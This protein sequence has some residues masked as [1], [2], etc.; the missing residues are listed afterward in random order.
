MLCLHCSPPTSGP[1]APEQKEPH[2]LLTDTGESSEHP[3][4]P[5][6][7]SQRGSQQAQSPRLPRCARNDR[8]THQPKNPTNTI[9]TPASRAEN[10][11]QRDSP[12]PDSQRRRLHHLRPQQRPYA[13]LRYAG[14]GS[15]HSIETRI[16]RTAMTER[17]TRE[18][19]GPRR[20][21]PAAQHWTAYVWMRQ[22]L[23]GIRSAPKA[24]LAHAAPARGIVH[25]QG[26]CYQ[27]GA[28]NP[29][30]LSALLHQQAN[31]QRLQRGT[32]SRQAQL[33]TNSPL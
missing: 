19:A 25:V 14:K 30:I 32:S 26:G 6:A 21:G 23:R 31:A 24:V 8:T 33:Q 18:I 7:V 12:P 29:G 10:R 15:Q 13:I 28:S 5:T 4:H 17:A 11:Q 27:T 1:R 16:A 2:S 3:V 20:L 22:H 9:L